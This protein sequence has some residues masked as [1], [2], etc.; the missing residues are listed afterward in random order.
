MASRTQPPSYDEGIAICCCPGETSNQITQI[1]KKDILQQQL[2]IIAFIKNT[3]PQIQQI[4]ILK[5]KIKI[6]LWYPI[7][8][9]LK[10]QVV[11]VH[12]F[13][14]DYTS[15]NTDHVKNI[16]SVNVRFADCKHSDVLDKTF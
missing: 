8:V 5:H 3:N 10:S 16:L 12:T 13:N 6:C 4:K 15:S 1:I 11:T 7:R 9:W 2:L 14:L